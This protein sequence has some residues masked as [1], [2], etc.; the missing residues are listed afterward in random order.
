VSKELSQ[1]SGEIVSS[2]ILNN[3]LSKLSKEQQVQ[4]VAY[5]CKSAGLDVAGSPFNL[6]PNKEGKLFLYAN[7]EAAAQLNQLRGLSPVVY[8]EELL[9]N[10]T[11]YKVTYRVTEGGRATED[12]GAVGL[13]KVKKVPGKEDEIRKLSPDEMADAIMKAHTKAKRRAILTHCGIGTN[14]SDEPLIVIDSSQKEEIKNADAT[15][16]DTQQEPVKEETPKKKSDHKNGETLKW[17]GKIDSIQEQQLPD[18]NPCWE[19]RCSDGTTFK[20][21]DADCFKLANEAGQHPVGIEYKLNGKGTKVVHR[22]KVEAL[23]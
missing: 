21:A 10:D 17:S 22:L 20:T 11:V 14:D 2:I 6:I 23:V 5:R 1:L 9:M 3:D 19:V 4:Y 15:V 8:K 13:V 16:K 7:K 18:G 12:C